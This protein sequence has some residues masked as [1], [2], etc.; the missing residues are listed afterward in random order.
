MTFYTSLIML[1][2]FDFIDF[3]FVIFFATIY[4]LMAFVILQLQKCIFISK[5]IYKKAQKLGLYNLT[6]IEP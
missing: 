1:M 6:S 4:Q 2:S 3:Y 5:R